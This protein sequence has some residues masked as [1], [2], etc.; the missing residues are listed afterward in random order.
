MMN[1]LEH[2]PHAAAFSDDMAKMQH[3]LWGT[4]TLKCLPAGC[5][6]IDKFN[7][8]LRKRIVR[9]LN[10]MKFVPNVATCP[11]DEAVDWLLKNP[12][13]LADFMTAVSCSQP[14]TQGLFDR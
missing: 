12:T 9:L 11:Q 1:R 6:A 7:K 5:I 13:H 4:V 8:E 14:A 3:L 2:S 10:I